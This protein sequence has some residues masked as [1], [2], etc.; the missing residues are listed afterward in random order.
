MK[1]FGESCSVSCSL[2]ILSVLIKL[3]AT[4]DKHQ[5]ALDARKHLGA[6]K[7]EALPLSRA[8]TRHGLHELCGLGRHCQCKGHGGNVST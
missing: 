5:M 2:E 8:K 7:R 4:P 6:L 1:P 3:S